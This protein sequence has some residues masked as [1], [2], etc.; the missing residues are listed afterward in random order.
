MAFRAPRT[1]RECEGRVWWLGSSV[2]FPLHTCFLLGCFIL[3]VAG[4]AVLPAGIFGQSL[5]DQQSILG[6]PAVLESGL[7]EAAAGIALVADLGRVHV[8]VQPFSWPAVPCVDH[9]GLN[10]IGSAAGVRSFVAE[11]RAVDT[12]LAIVGFELSPREQGACVGR[13]Q[14]HLSSGADTLLNLPTFPRC[15]VALEDRHAGRVSIFDL[16]PG[17]VSEQERLFRHGRIISAGGPVRYAARSAE[18]ARS[19]VLLMGRARTIAL[20]IFRALLSS[21]FGDQIGK[22]S[23]ERLPQDIVVEN[24]ETLR[25]FGCTLFQQVTEIDSAADSRGGSLQVGVRGFY[26]NR[27]AGN[28]ANTPLAGRVD[29]IA[30]I[31]SWD[32]AGGNHGQVGPTIV[33]SYRTLFLEPKPLGQR[34]FLRTGPHLPLVSDLIRSDS[35]TD[36]AFVAQQNGPRK[37]ATGL[38]KQRSSTTEVYPSTFQYLK[39]F[40]DT[41]TWAIPASFKN[42]DA[43]ANAGVETGGATG[44]PGCRNEAGGCERSKFAR[45]PFMNLKN[46]PYSAENGFVPV[47]PGSGRARTAAE[48]MMAPTAPEKGWTS[49]CWVSSCVWRAISEPSMPLW[50]G[51]SKSGKVL[52][53]E[54]QKS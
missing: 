19:S 37:T 29:I 24:R 11:N 12:D 26:Y 54:V 47:V 39:S 17:T 3:L 45:M 43:G 52:S 44:G 30:L 18:P 20:A 32:S 10:Q 9:G 53:S 49:H 21:P 28:V 35:S 15:V 38:S 14:Q 16:N 2:A 33:L 50:A 7:Q 42:G 1:N 31:G 25:V 51:H 23:N 36:I 48:S 6:Y 34:S 22:P 4:G 40:S 8:G 41:A 46:Q 27:Q 5:K 13:Q